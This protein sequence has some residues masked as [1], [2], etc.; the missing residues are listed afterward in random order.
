MKKK[1]LP[2][3]LLVFDGQKNETYVSIISSTLPTGR[4]SGK[5]LERLICQLNERKPCVI[6]TICLQGT[7]RIKK[8]G[9]KIAADFS[10]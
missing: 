8:S 6:D 1:T 4:Y 7:N 3:Y 10:Y 5:R 2:N 9:W